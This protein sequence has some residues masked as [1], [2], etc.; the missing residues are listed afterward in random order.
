[1]FLLRQGV[2]NFCT[3]EIHQSNVIAARTG[4]RP[5]YSEHVSRPPKPVPEFIDI[6]RSK[7]TRWNEKYEQL[8]KFKEKH[9]HCI[10]PTKYKINPQLGCWVS[11]Q[12]VHY[13]RMQVGRL[14][15]L[16]QEKIDRLN[17][18]DF[19]WDATEHAAKLTVRP[20]STSSDCN[21][22]DGSEGN[23][24][25]TPRGSKSATS[26]R[27]GKKLNEEAWITMYD[28]LKAYK[29]AFGTCLVPGK[30]EDSSLA[31]W[32]GAQ[33]RNYKARQR[34]EENAAAK[35]MSL[36]RIEL[37]E[38]IGFV[39]DARSDTS[40][41]SGVESKKSKRSGKKRNIVQEGTLS[42]SRRN[43]PRNKRRSCI[44]DADISEDQE[45][46][47][48]IPKAEAV[49]VEEEEHPCDKEEESDDTLKTKC[50]MAD[51]DDSAMKSS[52]TDAQESKGQTL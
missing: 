25:E 6:V 27:A 22:V 11:T 26:A 4:P 23:V 31:N 10:V 49:L 16:N 38:K 19:V 2:C 24:K 1:M 46:E 15:S 47:R 33:R 21:A 35:R 51:D 14:N 50:A 37:L 3:N 12:R 30:F 44:S 42:S 13:K 34:K 7:A 41:S 17:D 28:K 18:L 5:K 39:W 32:V 9:G 29:Q 45:N 48:E 36:E 20:M 43:L 40:T 8:K 52:S